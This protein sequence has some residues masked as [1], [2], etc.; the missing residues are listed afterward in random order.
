MC[1]NMAMSTSAHELVLQVELMNVRYLIEMV[2]AK[3]NI[4]GY[5]LSDDL[6]VLLIVLVLTLN[7]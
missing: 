3:M 4:D 2:V 1:Y 7:L 6:C 5:N